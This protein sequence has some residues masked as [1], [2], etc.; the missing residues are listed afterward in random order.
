MALIRNRRWLTQ[1]PRTQEPLEGWARQIVAWLDQQDRVGEVITPVVEIVIDNSTLSLNTNVQCTHG[2]EQ[3]VFSAAVP[4]V[5]WIL[6]G[7]KHSGVGIG[8]GSGVS[9]L[10]VDGTVA[11]N[12]I[13][14]RFLANGLTVDVSNPLTYWLYF[15]PFVERLPQ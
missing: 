7:A 10:Y 15:F 3:R 8:A 2:L 11:R 9:V 14:L 1:P 6:C 5:H 12:T 13:G 4:N